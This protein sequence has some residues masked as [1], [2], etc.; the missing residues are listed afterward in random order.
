VNHKDAKNRV[1]THILLDA[2][3]YC[4]FQG[5]MMDVSWWKDVDEQIWWWL[6]TLFPFNGKDAYAVDNASVNGV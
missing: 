6:A 2:D 5:T 1:G 3:A 4:L